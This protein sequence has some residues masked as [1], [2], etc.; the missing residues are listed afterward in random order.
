MLLISPFQT[1][2]LF[3]YLGD[4]Y[5]AVTNLVEDQS[6]D[7]VKRIAEFAI[8][9]VKAAQETPI[10]IDDIDEKLGYVNIRAGFHS[11]PVVANVVGSLN[12]RFCLFGDVVNTS[13][14]MESTSERNRIQCSERSACLLRDQCSS[15]NVTSRGFIPIKGKG[16]LC[17]FW[18]N[19]WQSDWDEADSEDEV[20][21]A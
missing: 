1:H 11:G 14:R 3:V 17:T 9:A 7:H 8:A 15:I 20:I 6:E 13:S 4:A 21:S 19:D 16:K 18:I 5:M 10:D 12:P 2:F